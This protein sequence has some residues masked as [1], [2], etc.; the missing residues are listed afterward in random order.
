MCVFA[1][2]L[3]ET[4]SRDCPTGRYNSGA[5]CDAC[6]RG[7]YSHPVDDACPL[8]PTGKY[9]TSMAR[10]SCS[11]C[12]AGKYLAET[13]VTTSSCGS[14]PPGKFQA[15]GAAG[16]CGPCPLGKFQPGTGGHKLC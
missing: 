6:D 11:G 2:F 10:S 14:C 3:S 1:F 15:L 7:K 4:M 16:S 5:S 12:V 8:C 13:G 9:Q